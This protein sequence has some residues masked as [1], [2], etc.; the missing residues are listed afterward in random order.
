[1]DPPEPS[2]P[3]ALLARLAALEAQLAA[4]DAQRRAERAA[5]IRLQRLAR[6]PPPEDP[7]LVAYRPIA[8]LH[9]CFSRRNGTPRQPAL[10]PAARAVLQLERAVPPGAL[11][12]LADFSHVWVLYAFHA[13]TNA[14]HCAAKAA[15]AVPR[16]DGA[17]RGVLATRTPHR[18]NA[19]GLSL[20]RLL[21]V[22]AAA[23]TVT[24]GGLDCVDGSP[25]LDLKPLVPFCDCPPDARAPAWVAAA[26]AEE[27]LAVAGVALSDDA[28]AELAAAYAAAETARRGAWR[29]AHPP[30]APPAPPALY[31]DGAAFCALVRQ[32]LSLD[33]RALRER[34]A[35]RRAVYHVILC[36]VEVDYTLDG[37][38]RVE[39]LGGRPALPEAAWAAQQDDAAAAAA[40]SDGSE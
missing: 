23:G 28:A 12:G 19:L 25:V 35:P 34:S 7:R 22:D 39:V 31:A 32:V 15:V 30:P 1:M 38:R 21:A 17:S 13:N 33:I 8:T 36:C 18:P 14:H 29:A 24:L 9:S 10:V 20:G 5:R 37:A 3:Q 6:A 40:L 27:P 16:L 2:D 4:C 26:A 11:A